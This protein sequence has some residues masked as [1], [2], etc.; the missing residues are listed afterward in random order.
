MILEKYDLVFK[1]TCESDKS[2]INR[3]IL[4]INV[5]SVLHHKVNSLLRRQVLRNLQ[6]NRAF[7]RFYKTSEWE[8]VGGMKFFQLQKHE[9]K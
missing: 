1:T 9:I 3:I 5:L 4:L 7:K 2:T 8:V 6:R